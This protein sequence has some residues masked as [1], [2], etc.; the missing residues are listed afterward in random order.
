[1]EFY[2][3]FVTKSQDFKKVKFVKFDTFDPNTEIHDSHLKSV[4]FSDEE[5]FNSIVGKICA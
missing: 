5:K 3:S 2:S 1:M 4:N